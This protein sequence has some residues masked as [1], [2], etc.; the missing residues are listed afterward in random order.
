MIIAMG[1]VCVMVFVLQ[2]ANEGRI[3]PTPIEKAVLEANQRMIAT[4]T[5]VDRFFADILDFD[6]GMII[7]N[8]LLFKTRQEAYDAVKKGFAGVT[9]VQRHYDQTY[10]KVLSAKHALLTGTG[11]T[12]IELENGQSFSSPFAVSLVFQLDK[13]Q[14]KVLHGHYS[15]PM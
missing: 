2:A 8:G 4:G 10:V 12:K 13:G 9:K 6:N 5:D 1:L 11:V 14:W 7:Q 15:I 3:D